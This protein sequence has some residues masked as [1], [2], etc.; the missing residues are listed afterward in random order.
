MRN[1]PRKSIMISDLTLDE[2]AT[3]IIISRAMAVS[4]AIIISPIII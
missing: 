1:Y 3:T 2:P 4:S